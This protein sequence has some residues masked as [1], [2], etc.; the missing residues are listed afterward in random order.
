MPPPTG[1]TPHGRYLR[2]RIPHRLH[3][4]HITARTHPAT[5]LSAGQARHAI[6]HPPPIR[7]RVGCLGRDASRS[8]RR[9]LSR[10]PATFL[11]RRNL[12]THR[13][14]RTSSEEHTSEL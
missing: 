2:S 11:E 8:H 14:T 9:R 4:R 12:S 6:L 1:G 5:E 3:G 10:R 7:R 13:L